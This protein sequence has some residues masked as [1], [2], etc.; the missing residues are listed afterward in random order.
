MSSAEYELASKLA[1]DA[2]GL[3]PDARTEFLDTNCPPDLRSFVEQLISAHD[4]P[5]QTLFDT[6]I[7]GIDPPDGKSAA[8]QLS[9]GTRLGPYE[10]RQVIGSGG[11]GT[12]YK[13]RDTRL[14]RDVAIK[15]SS[16]QFSK[17]FEREARAVAALNHPNI[18]TLYDV[19]PNY[20]VMELVEGK[21][22]AGPMPIA[23][24][25]RLGNQVAAAL[26]A[27]HRKGI[28][29][30]DLKPQN[31]LATKSGV[32]LLD[33][34]LAKFERSPTPNQTQTQPI[35]KKHT[36]L[37]TLQYMA[38]EQLEGKDADT[39]SDIF[40][41]G[42]VL[43]EMLCG[44][45]AFDAPS[46]A[47]LMA[48]ILH[49]EL[50]SINAGPLD[51]VIRRCL[52]KDPEERWQNVRDVLI[53]LQEASTEAPKTS[54]TLLSRWRG[55]LIW[56]MGTVVMATVLAVIAVVRSRDRAQPLP[57]L[58]FS[59]F[60]PDGVRFG[61]VRSEGPPMISPD[62]T[63]IAFCG[64]DS[65]GKN[66]IWI[67]RMDGL[68]SQPLEGT[69]DANY[70]FWS[71]D[72]H[73][74][75]FF[76]D[77]ILKKVALDGGPTT[78]LGPAQALGGAWTQMGGGAGFILFTPS[79]A[80]GLARISASG[81][82]PVQITKIV[83][84]R[85]ETG[86]YQ[87]QFL[88]DGQHFLFLATHDEDER[89]DVCVGDL[90]GKPD[91]K[92]TR[93]LMSGEAKVWWA[94]PGHL[95]F[96]RDN[97][98]MAQAFDASTVELNGDPFLVAKNVGKG[99]N[100]WTS[101]FSVSS[102][103]VLVW[104]SGFDARRHLAWFDRSGRQIGGF[105]QRER[106]W[107]ASLSPGGK[108]I[109]MIGPELAVPSGTLGAA[110]PEGSRVWV[111]DL[112]RGSALPLT[113][114]EGFDVAPVWSAF[115]DRI[116][117]GR[118]AGSDYGLYALDTRGTGPEELLLKTTRL[119]FPSSWSSDGN[120]ILFLQKTSNSESSVMVL[121]LSG[122]RQPFPLGI[123]SPLPLPG[124]VQFS[125]DG[126]WIAYTSA[127]TGH[128]EVYLRPF[129][130]RHP[131]SISGSWRVSTGIAYL[132]RWRRDGKEIF[133]SSRSG[134]MAV[135]VQTSP[136]LALGNPVNLFKI[137]DEDVNRFSY[138]VSPDGQKFLISHLPEDNNRPINVALNWTA[139]LKR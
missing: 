67:R 5:D 42:L 34:G 130:A 18:C 33:F 123:R 87:P 47:R 72:S 92:N 29:H 44:K 122:K 7:I 64:T 131:T 93:R 26:D 37:G 103:G 2:F 66:R 104:R 99:F 134:M 83:S 126:R 106:Y 71:P 81:G 128:Y 25:T 14:D 139:G 22:L 90:Q 50:P 112:A 32:K 48:A 84:A 136:K 107:S 55:R 137:F 15:I 43:Y 60:P 16:A 77:G 11:M 102:N 40:A 115:D 125:P 21:P 36:L 23:D 8:K 59:I 89:A 41:L 68:A 58:R 133:Y 20:L 78:S 6:N 86:H 95:L 49:Q 31:I 27:A 4:N 113:S 121:P 62:G 97:N 119:S 70:P 80:D 120:F 111:W 101:D 51:R 98:L 94:P 30:R 12:V 63:L 138:D 96:L 28:V 3:S 69:E 76:A 61:G 38:P 105:E 24:A 65:N 91:Q 75:G 73:Y 85:G 82:N 118:R 9:P 46:E 57:N 108:Q 132:P 116:A 39:R 79:G 35:T 114:G 124:A 54:P 117:F 74:L 109:A 19:G 10:I 17:R 45:P 127:E 53:E 135:T 110:S 129:D 1:V 88:P 52:K 100:R 13:A 56:G